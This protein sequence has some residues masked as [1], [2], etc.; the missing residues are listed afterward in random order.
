MI[1]PEIQPDYTVDQ[2]SGSVWSIYRDPQSIGFTVITAA[3]SEL[4]EKQEE[5][6]NSLM[7]RYRAAEIGKEVG[8][9]ALWRRT[10]PIRQLLGEGRE[11]KVYEMGEAFAVREVEGITEEHSVIAKLERMDSINSVIEHGLPRWLNLPK[12][13]GVRV[14]AQTQRTYTLMDR[15]DNGITVEDIIEYPKLPRSKITTVRNEMGGS[16]AD[17]KKQV[18]ALY[19]NA[20]EILSAALKKNGKDPK[21]FLTD[22]IPR[23]VIVEG[24]MTSPVANSRYRLSVIDQYRD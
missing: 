20:Y 18:P 4:L 10:E 9:I 12:H 17:A 19:E 1:K 5:V 23:N 16:I 15:I 11:A 8:K 2:E 14:D 24:R 22:W 21:R 13:Y 3:G 7:R 6:V